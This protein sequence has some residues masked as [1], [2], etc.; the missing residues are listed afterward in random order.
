MTTIE[1]RLIERVRENPAFVVHELEPGET[2]HRIHNKET[3][4]RFRRVIGGS[5]DWSSAREAKVFLAGSH[6][7]S[8]FI[9]SAT[10][11]LADALNEDLSEEARVQH[12][13][14]AQARIMQLLDDRTPPAWWMAV[15]SLVK[16]RVRGGTEAVSE[17]GETVPG[18]ENRGD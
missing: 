2:I 5:R 7:D 12:Y 8:G 13:D 9:E 1:D 14:I 15:E 18:A 11:H 10:M 6:D 17:Q 3:Y 16:G 4:E